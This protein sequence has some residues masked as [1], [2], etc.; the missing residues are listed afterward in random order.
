MT[1]NK[2]VPRYPPQ[3][4]GSADRDVQN[5]EK[6]RRPHMIASIPG[7]AEIF[8]IAIIAGIIVLPYWKIFSK[9]GYSGAFSL[10][11]LIPLLNVIMLFFL[12]YADWPALK[13]EQ[14]RK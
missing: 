9:A 1:A 5:I 14:R 12:A 6:K 4:A 10:L 2:R 11:M 7:P 13:N 8:V 3:R